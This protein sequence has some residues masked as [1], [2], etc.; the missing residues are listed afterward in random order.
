MI[1]RRGGDNVQ[2][3]DVDLGKMESNMNTKKGNLKIVIILL[4]VITRKNLTI[5]MIHTRI[6][7]TKKKNTLKMERKRNT[8]L[9]TVFIKTRMAKSIRRGWEGTLEVGSLRE[10]V[11]MMEAIKRLLLRMPNL[12]G[13][14]VL[15]LKMM[16]MKSKLLKLEVLLSLRM[17]LRKY[18]LVLKVLRL[19]MD[20]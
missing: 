17:L 9:Y 11:L 15:V 5:R 13:R 20:I 4:A 19:R 7:A 3:K 12:K 14:K 2:R 10:R 1:R 16:I 18:L 8:I 6:T